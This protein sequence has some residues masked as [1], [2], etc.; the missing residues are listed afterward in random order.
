MFLSEFI[1]RLSEES[2][3][4]KFF[5]PNYLKIRIQFKYVGMFKKKK[6]KRSL[7]KF[8]IL[9]CEKLQRCIWVV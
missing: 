6:K 9:L 8:N 3:T 5:L 7:I 2:A 1:F 4:W